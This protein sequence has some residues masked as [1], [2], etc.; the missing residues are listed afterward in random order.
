MD[1][2]DMERLAQ[3]ARREPGPDVDVANRVLRSI[4]SRQRAAQ[5]VFD[6]QLAMCAVTAV[7]MAVLVAVPAVNAW[8]L[9]SDPLTGV[10]AQ[11]A[12]VLP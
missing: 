12:T 10:F 11:L 4:E 1:M 2:Y 8:L 6:H 7:V 3:A 5:L 9:L